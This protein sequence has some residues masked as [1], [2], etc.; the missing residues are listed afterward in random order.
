[1]ANRLEG[2]THAAGHL[3]CVTLGIPAGTVVDAAVNGSAAIQITKL[4]YQ[5]YAIHYGQADGTDI[6]DAI[7]PIHTVR[8]ATAVIMAVEV[9]CLD[10][11]SVGGAVPKHFHVDLKKYTVAV[12]AGVSVLAAPVDYVSGTADCTVLAGTVALSA[13]VDGDTLG[14]EVDAVGADGTQGQG[15]I[16]TVTIRETPQ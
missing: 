5:Q 1:M 16:V 8:G 9:A 7:M 15:L 10:A 13:L 4:Q 12:P 6:V 3:S 2:D 14:V 11:P